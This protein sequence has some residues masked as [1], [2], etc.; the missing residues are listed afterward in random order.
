MSNSRDSCLHRTRTSRAPRA[1]VAEVDRRLV[2]QERLGFGLILF[3]ATPWSLRCR[4][5]ELVRLLR[6][7]QREWARIMASGEFD[8]RLNPGLDRRMR[9]EQIGETLARV[10]DAHF[11]HRR[12]GSGKFAAA[13]DLA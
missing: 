11:H 5:R 1:T 12:V 7:L 13:L 10:V 2:R 4:R 6:R 9:S 3:G 8:Q